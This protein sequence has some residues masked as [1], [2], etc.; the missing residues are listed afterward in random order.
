MVSHSDT[1]YPLSTN[2]VV[3]GNFKEAMESPNNSTVLCLPW[4]QRPENHGLNNKS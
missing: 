4:L 2:T 3:A 1:T